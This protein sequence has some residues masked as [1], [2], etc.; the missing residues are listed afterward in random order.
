MDD[1]VTVFPVGVHVP[2]GPGKRN[3]RS[4]VLPLTK[5]NLKQSKFIL[6]A[7]QA[8]STRVQALGYPCYLLGPKDVSWFILGAPTIPQTDI[9]FSVDLTDG[10]TLDDLFQQLEVVKQRGNTFEYTDNSQRSCKIVIE[11]AS[12]PESLG[13]K[14]TLAYSLTKD[15]IPIYNPGHTLLS[16]LTQPRLQNAILA[17]YGLLERTYEQIV[18]VLKELSKSCVDLWKVFLDGEK[19]DRLD[20]LVKAVCG[21]HPGLKEVFTSLGSAFPV[22]PEPIVTPA[23]ILVQ[24]ENPRDDIVFEAAEMTVKVLCEAGYSCA[25][26]G[27]VATY[28]QANDTGLPLPN[29]T[30]ITVFSDHDIKTIRRLLSKH[31]LFYI[32]RMK[33]PGSD[34]RS[35]VL[36]YRIHGRGR[37]F[38]K[39]KLCKVHF[40]M[41]QEQMSYETREGL[42]L[43]PLSTLLADTLRIWHDRSIDEPQ[44]A[45]KHAVYVRALLK[46]VNE[47]DD[48]SSSWAANY[49][50]DELQIARMELFCSTFEESQDDWRR[51]GYNTV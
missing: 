42:P 51:L 17:D 25:V 40:V 3:K 22:E 31:H 18:P 7:V 14:A 4:E 33:V 36:F 49:L 15:G 6:S 39:W 35:P 43:V 1:N 47:S 21:A 38:R 34:T 24:E 10:V 8:I 2:Q 41:T 5:E 13:L 19:R 28:L 32:A 26:S 50:D 16:H 11:Q 37:G 27:M 23:P 44:E 46:A 9:W 45:G 12:A 30:E 20:E 29:C 48:G